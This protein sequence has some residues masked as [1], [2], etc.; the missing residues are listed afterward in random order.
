MPAPNAS[1]LS[2]EKGFPEVKPALTAEKALSE[3]K[4]VATVELKAKSFLTGIS[5]APCAPFLAGRCQQGD[6]CPYNHN[7]DQIFG[8]S[9][10][11]DP[12]PQ[13]SVSK[14][15]NKRQFQEDS[16]NKSPN[17]SKK[18]QSADK[19][20]DQDS[21]PV[22]RARLTQGIEETKQRLHPEDDSEGQY[23]GHYEGSDEACYWGDEY[24]LYDDYSFGYEAYDESW[25]PG[26]SEYYECWEQ[27]EY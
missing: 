17:K 27:E 25:E 16:E 9:A 5:R 15:K 4:P 26:Y 24:E 11:E 7:R 2:P 1:A 21:N 22:K 14:G 19:D 23:W 6:T 20:C 8:T 3:V 18:I 12:S 13:V 10:L